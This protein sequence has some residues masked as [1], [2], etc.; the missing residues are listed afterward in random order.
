MF[1]SGEG[2]LVAGVVGRQHVQH[3]DDLGAV[4]V[5]LLQSVGQK[6]L[7]HELV[8]RLVEQELDRQQV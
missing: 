1:G 6:L 3:S 2:V 7:A 5:V 4:G 8:E